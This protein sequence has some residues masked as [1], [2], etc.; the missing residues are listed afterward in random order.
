MKNTQINHVF[1][2][3]IPDKYQTDIGGFN[4]KSH[5]DKEV[6]YQAIIDKMEYINISILSY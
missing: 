6:I 2:N 1:G 4:D 3:G 5:T